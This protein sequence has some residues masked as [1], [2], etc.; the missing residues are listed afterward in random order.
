MGIEQPS[1][2]RATMSPKVIAHSAWRSLDLISG[3]AS[4]YEVRTRQDPVHDMHDLR[5]LGGKSW[6]EQ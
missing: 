4:P 2:Y 3:T 1:C 6:F 5:T